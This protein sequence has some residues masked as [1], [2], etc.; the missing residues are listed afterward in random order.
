MAICLLELDF[1][2]ALCSTLA[3]SLVAGDQIRIH[4][5]GTETRRGIPAISLGS[6]SPPFDPFPSPRS[7]SFQILQRLA[8][9]QPSLHFTSQLLQEVSDHRARPKEV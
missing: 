4:W 8:F 1:E 5:E 3:D 2:M 7:S 9:S 6:T